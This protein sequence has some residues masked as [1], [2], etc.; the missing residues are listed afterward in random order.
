LVEALG[1]DIGKE[2]RS[3]EAIGGFFLFT[4]TV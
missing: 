2:M 3:E 4:L 1:V